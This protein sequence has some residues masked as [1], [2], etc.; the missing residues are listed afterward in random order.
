MSQFNPVHIIFLQDEFWIL[1]SQAIFDDDD[2]DD[3]S[4]K[5]G[6]GEGE[7]AIRKEMA[8]KTKAKV[9]G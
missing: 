6:D 7:K 3:N 9:G 8:R 2:N 1:S 5:S 4:R